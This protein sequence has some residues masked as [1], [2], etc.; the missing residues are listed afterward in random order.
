MHL[1]KYIVLSQLL[2]I[3]KINLMRKYIVIALLLTGQIGIAQEVTTYYLIRHAEKER[4]DPSN[5]DPHLT[6][7]GKERAENWQNIFKEVPFDIVYSTP[8]HRTR[9]TAQPTANAQ[10][11]AVE[12]YDPQNLYNASF[13]EKNEGKI[14]L[15][16]GH[17]NTTP[18]L[19]N[20]ILGREEYP[21]IDDRNNGN[22]YILQVSP[23]GVTSQLLS[24]E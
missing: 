7:E 2:L 23:Q 14:V 24:I 5:R 22:L 12:S 6:I 10:H 15:V 21:Q 13:K 4:I 8:Y 16:V 18:A 20:K 9:E 17:S 11:L 19:A 3:P 1:K